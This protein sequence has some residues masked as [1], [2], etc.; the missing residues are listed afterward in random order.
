MISST[1]D[2]EANVQEIRKKRESDEED[3][4]YMK[5]HEYIDKAIFEDN[6]L[7]LELFEQATHSSIPW[8]CKRESDEE[9][10][11]YMKFHEYI[12]EAIL[13]DNALALE[14]FEQATP[15]NIPWFCV[16]CGCSDEFSIL[17]ERVCGC[18]TCKKGCENA[19][20]RR[21]RGAKRSKEWHE[22]ADKMEAFFEAFDRLSVYEEKDEFV[23]FK[24]TVSVLMGILESCQLVP[25]VEMIRSSILEF[26]KEMLEET[27]SIK[28]KGRTWLASAVFIKGLQ[29]I[30]TGEW[31]GAIHIHGAKFYNSL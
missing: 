15:S 13:E 1:K 4:N 25:E 16:T 24:Q 10:D 9:D 31:E 28:I 12:D 26:C 7:A 29:F 5:L 27:D 2:F 20:S 23:G 19:S 21:I 6:P 17:G 18:D 3:D 30:R 14:L 8:C 11:N 22:T